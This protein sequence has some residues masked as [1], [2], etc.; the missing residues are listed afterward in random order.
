MLVTDEAKIEEFLSH[1]V[2]RELPY[3]E[4][5][6]VFYSAANVYVLMDRTKA[7]TPAEKG[8][9]PEWNRETQLFCFQ[10]D[11]VPGEV[12]DYFGPEDDE[13]FRSYMNTAY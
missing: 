12:R 10:G 9:D 1:A 6:T 2:S 11:H 7:L 8:G 13:V 3:A 4:P 5:M